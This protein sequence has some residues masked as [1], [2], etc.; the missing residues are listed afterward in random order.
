MQL[1]CDGDSV[2]YLPGD[3]CVRG[4][5]TKTVVGGIMA[6]KGVGILIPRTGGHVFFTAKGALQIWLG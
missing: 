5:Y 3:R 2:P 4:L 6:P 1:N